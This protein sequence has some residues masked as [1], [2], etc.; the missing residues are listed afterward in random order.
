MSDNILLHCHDKVATVE[1]NRPESKNALDRDDRVA[2]KQVLDTVAKDKDIR[3]VVLTGAGTAFCAGGNLHARGKSHPRGLTWSLLHDVQPALE[4]IARMDKP[5]IAAVNGPAV[6][7]GMS[8]ALACDL[9]V[10]E[11]GAYLLS[12]FIRL[13]LIPDGGAAWYLAHR[14]G[15][16]RMFEIVA[17]AG[18][19][20][21]Q[22]CVLWGVANRT[23]AAGGARTEAEAWARKLAGYAPTGMRYTKRLA[24]LATSNR[25]EESLMLEAEFQSLCSNS[26]DTHEAVKAFMEKR[27]ADFTGLDN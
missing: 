14:I 12:Q 2:L 3:A 23:A 10:I 25:L 24:R 22:K 9:M 16:A 20:D 1:I 7:F 15:Y 21:A 4:C 13:G 8:L 26:P 11:D 18:K 27:D 19:L 5:V 6:G 17:D